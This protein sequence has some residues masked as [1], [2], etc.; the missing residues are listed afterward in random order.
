[1]L[2]TLV[3]A[4]VGTG[5]RR[6]ATDLELHA[7]AVV[8][9]RLFW[10]EQPEQSYQAIEEFSGR[11]LDSSRRPYAFSATG[12]FWLAPF[13]PRPM[14]LGFILS[15]LQRHEAIQIGV[16]RVVERDVEARIERLLS[17]AS[18]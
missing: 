10:L 11:P 6:N 1:M 5:D 15:K 13:T 16:S 3:E 14:S 7:A 4:R 9:F 18:R 12:K 2:Q 17:N 8:L